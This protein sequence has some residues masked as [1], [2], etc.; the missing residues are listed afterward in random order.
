VP[1]R[2]VTNNLSDTMNKIIIHW[3]ALTG[4]DIKAGK[5]AVR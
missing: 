4:H 5:V 3:S 1:H 2:T